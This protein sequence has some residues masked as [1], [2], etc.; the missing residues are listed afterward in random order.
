MNDRLELS[1]VR[2]RCRIG[3]PDWERKSKQKIVLDL[4]AETDLEKAG[5]SDALEHS[6]DYHALE[7]RLRAVAERGER[8]LLES[9]AED[10]ADTA[11]GFDERI[12]VV[13]IA[14]HKFPKVMPKTERVTVR[15]ERKR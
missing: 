11:L 1:G 10:L 5:R 14:V 13:R 9:L 15:I 4:E 6:V 3:V 7:E 12:A 8:K 2:C